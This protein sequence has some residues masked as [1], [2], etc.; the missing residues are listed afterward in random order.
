MLSNQLTHNLEFQ[1]LAFGINGSADSSATFHYADLIFFDVSNP[2]AT[3]TIQVG[4]TASFSGTFSEN[5]FAGGVGGT[6]RII[7]ATYFLRTTI[8]TQPFDHTFPVVADFAGDTTTDFVEVPLGVPTSF[9]V[10]SL[11]QTRTL[12]NPENESGGF[13]KVQS[14]TQFSLAEIF[15]LPTGFSVSSVDG[16]ILD[17]QFTPVPVPT[18]NAALA[19]VVLLGISGARRLNVVDEISRYSP[20]SNSRHWYAS[21]C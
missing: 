12:M 5:W 11:L 21:R 6:P 14:V 1:S 9:S 18:G 20:E 2:A 13:V 4:A 3:G 16:R 17:N 15:D 10:L 8:G 19:L 7:A